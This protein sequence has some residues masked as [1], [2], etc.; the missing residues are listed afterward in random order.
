MN[1][2]LTIARERFSELVD[3][4]AATGAELVIT[5]HGRPV[6]V[7][8]AHDEYEELVETLNILSDPDAMAALAEAESDIEAGRLVDLP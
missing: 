6:A 7:L 4:V 2:P 8:I 5:K 3:E 1:T